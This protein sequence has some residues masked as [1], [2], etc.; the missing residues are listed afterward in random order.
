MGTS[1]SRCPRCGSQQVADVVYGRREE[2]A[3][4]VLAGKVF[5]GGEKPVPGGFPHFGCLECGETWKPSRVHLHRGG[6]PS[7]C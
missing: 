4:L 3:P 1:R 7:L 5:H 6:R 2:V